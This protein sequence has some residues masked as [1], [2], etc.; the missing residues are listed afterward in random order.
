MWGCGEGW[1]QTMLETTLCCKACSMQERSAS[2][3]S[4]FPQVCHAIFLT[5]LDHLIIYMFCSTAA[6]MPV[7]E[8]ACNDIQQW[9]PWRNSY[10]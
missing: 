10:R 5:L 4:W 8:A 2:N 6:A 9:P 7:A 3:L 1:W